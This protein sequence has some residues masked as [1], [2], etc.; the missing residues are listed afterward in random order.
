[1]CAICAREQNRSAVGKT[2]ISLT[3]RRPQDLAPSTL[4]WLL[5]CTIAPCYSQAWLRVAAGVARSFTSRS[6]GA[7][8]RARPLPIYSIYIK[9]KAVPVAASSSAFA[10]ARPARLGEGRARARPC[11]YKILQ[12]T[13]PVR[14]PTHADVS[15]ASLEGRFRRESRVFLHN[16]DINIR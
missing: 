10:S 1:M 9:A 8:P 11:G 2:T 15:T 6:S 16:L 14:H 13:Q 7:L 3:S 12:K 5:A 4:A